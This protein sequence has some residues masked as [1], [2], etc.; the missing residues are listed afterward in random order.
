MKEKKRLA[1]LLSSGLSAVVFIQA[2]PLLPFA[3]IRA[4]EIAAEEALRNDL[5][6]YADDFPEGAVEF[7]EEKGSITEG[8]GDR[9][10]TVVRLGDPKDAM[11]VDVKAYDVTAQY[12]EDYTMYTKVKLKKNY[13]DDSQVGTPSVQAAMESGDFQFDIEEG[14]GNAVEL[15]GEPVAPVGEGTPFEDD[16]PV[17]E[18]QAEEEAAAEETAENEDEYEVV[19]AQIAEPEEKEASSEETESSGLRAAYRE[20]TGQDTVNTNWRGEYEQ[21][22]AEEAAKEA[23]NEVVDSFN[24]AF[25][26]LNFEPGE[27][28]KTIYIHVNDDDKA[29]SPESTSLILGNA[30]SGLIGVNMQYTVNIEDNE[31]AQPITFAMKD[32][33]IVTDR[34]ATYAEVTVERTSGIDY[35]ANLTYRTASGTAE[36]Y[37][38][39]MPVDGKSVAFAPGQTEQKV[40]IDLTGN[41]TVGSWFT[42]LIDQEMNNADE[43]RAETRVYIGSKTADSEDILN[44]PPAEPK[45]APQ[46]ISL[47]S[48]N[49]VKGTETMDGIKYETVALSGYDFGTW[50]SMHS[51]QINSLRDAAFVKLSYELLNGGTYGF[52]YGGDSLIGYIADIYSGSRYQIFNT[53][54]FNK[55]V[56]SLNMLQ[57]YYKMSVT[58]ITLYYP[59]YSVISANENQK[60]K[61]TNYVCTDKTLQANKT[62]DSPA[63]PGWQ[64]SWAG[65]T[66]LLSQNSPTG[67]FQNFSSRRDQGLTVDKWDVYAGSAGEREFISDVKVVGCDKDG[68]ALNIINQLKSEGW[69]YI[70]HDLNKNAGGMFI[71]LAYKTTPNYSEAIKDFFVWYG[72]SGKDKDSL[73]HDGYTY[74]HASYKGDSEFEKYKGDLNEN[75][76]GRDVYLFYSKQ[77]RGDGKGV[78]S[79]SFNSDSSS[80]IQCDEGGAADLNKGAGG[81]Y[82]YMHIGKDYTN[83]VGTL[84]GNDTGLFTYS[85]INNI[86]NSTPKRTA[87]QNA[88]NK[89]YVS[90]TYSP[91]KATVEFKAEEASAVAFNGNKGETAGFKVGQKLECTQID[92][93][94]MTICDV[95]EGQEINPSN[96]HR[97]AYNNEWV[98]SNVVLRGRIFKSM[99]LADIEKVNKKILDK[100]NTTKSSI[101]ITSDVD[102]DKE[103]FTACYNRPTLKYEYTPSENSVTNEA[104]KWGGIYVTP[105]DDPEDILG[106]SDYKTPLTITSPDLEVLQTIYVANV[107]LDANREI[108]ETIDKQT[109]ETLKN[110]TY[111]IWTYRDKESGMNKSAMGNSFAHRP[112]YNNETVNYHFKYSK[113]DEVMQGLSGKVYTLEVPLFNGSN[114]KKVKTPAV[115]VQLLVGG[116]NGRSGSDGSYTID[117]HFDINDN[118]SVF[119]KYDSLTTL[120]NVAIS[121]NTKY[122]IDIDVN[123]NDALKVVSSLME[124]D[125]LINT[126]KAP[127]GLADI[128]RTYN[129]QTADG[130]TLED[131]KYYLTVNAKGSAG[132]VPK[133]AEFRVYNKKGEYKSDLTKRVAFEQDGINGSLTYEVNPMS[134]TGGKLEVGD[135]FTV[136]LYDTK[137][138]KYFEHHTG[139]VVAEPLTKMFLFN[140]DSWSSDSDN[141]FIKA[142]GN[143]SYVYDF[144]LDVLTQP[145]TDYRDSDNKRH[146]F[147]YIGFGNTTNDP[148][149]LFEHE[150]KTKKM[151]EEM[152]NGTYVP[153]NYKE[154]SFQG[155]SSLGTDDD[156]KPT[157]NSSWNLKINIAMILDCIVDEEEGD[158]KGQLY[159]NDFL[160]IAG[161]TAKYDRT[162]TVPVKAVNVNIALHFAVNPLPDGYGSGV[163]WHFYTDPENTTKK[164]MTD[165]TDESKASDNKQGNSTINLLSWKGVKSRGDIGFNAEIG[166]DVNVSFKDILTVGG[167][168]N[169]QVENDVIY[170]TDK[171]FDD[172]GAVFLTPSVYIKLTFL[173]IPLWSTTFD[174]YWGNNHI[175]KKAPRKLTP[176]TEEEMQT[177]ILFNKTSEREI[178]DYNELY[179]DRQWGGSAFRQF[180]PG[181]PTS[182]EAI[183]EAVLQTGFYNDTDIRIQDLGNGKYI[184]LFI[185]LVLGRAT[186][187]AFGAYYSIY[188]GKSWSVPQ[189]LEDDGT[190]DDVP[191]I[192]NAGSKGWLIAWSDASRKID[193]NEN[194]GSMLN[195]Y[196]LTGRFFN[197]ET[198]EL[199]DVMEITKT[200]GSDTVCDSSPEISYYEENGKE[201][202]KIY[203]T[204]SEYSVS[205]TEDGEVIGDILNPYELKAVRNYDFENDKWADT[206]F[207]NVK[208]YLIN[209]RGEEGYKTY[210]D[211]WYGQEFLT[212]APTLEVNETLDDLGYWKEGTTATVAETDLSQ[213]MAQDSAVITYNNLSLQAYTLDK[214]GMAQEDHDENLY[215]QIYNYHDDEYHHPILISGN[216][217]EISD[218]K[219]VRMPVKADD[220]TAEATYLYWLED[221]NI[222]RINITNL[223]KN[224]LVEG[225]TANGQEYYYINKA[226]DSAFEPEQVLAEPTIS[227]NSDGEKSVDSAITSFKVRQNG[228]YNYLMWT[229]SIQKF[230]EN[231]EQRFEQQLFAIRENS[232]TGEITYPVQMTDKTDQYINKF[233]Y[234]VTDNGELDVLT[235]R[236]TLGED[237]HPDMNTSE[238]VAFHIKPSDKL[239]ISD[240]SDAS[241]AMNDDGS[242]AAQVDLTLENKNFNTQKNIVVEVQDNDGNVVYTTDSPI[243]SYEV[244]ET[245][246]DDGSVVFEE[247]TKTDNTNKL[248]MIGGQK[249]PVSVNIPMN[250]DGNYSGKI[251]LKVDGNTVETR[252]LSGQLK[253]EL[254]A[255]DFISAVTDRNEIRLDA[256]VKNDNYLPSGEETVK[257]GYVDADGKQIE[258]GTVN[259]EPLDANEETP[260]NLT[261][262][263]SF[264]KFISQLEEDGSLTDSLQLYMACDDFDTV[265]STVCLTASSEEYKLM[266]GLKNFDAK[267]SQYNY[268]GGLDKLESFNVGEKAFM[269]LWLE[270]DFAQNQKQYTNRTKLVWEEKSDSVASITKDGVITAKGDGTTTLNGYIVPIDTES[271]LYETGTSNPVDNY[272]YKPSA[273]VIPISANV[274]VGDGSTEK[275]GNIATDIEILSMAAK[276]Y[277]S[278]NDKVVSTKSLKVNDDGKYEISLFDVNNELADKYVIDP[279]TGIGVNSANEAVNLPQTGM[280][281]IVEMLIIITSVLMVGIGLIVVMYSRKKREEEIGSKE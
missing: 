94:T 170:S 102:Y 150:T 265:Y 103:I 160:I 267:P 35:Y 68:D 43:E 12:G 17:E 278:K 217:S 231:D 47:D 202:M 11:S 235:D 238:L 199:S 113:P 30:T 69:Q 174:W 176:P 225:K 141:F 55:D 237:G 98:L 222:K 61:G 80:A 40:R 132:F 206:Y 251:V 149:Q 73:S 270:G 158:R 46:I 49:V 51:Y 7:Y 130:M 136:T 142:L 29:E 192:C 75:A 207:G 9:E 60:L 243:A 209:K 58:G 215:L 56:I 228:D 166:A 114:T 86:I 144:A 247:L 67:Y 156:F 52:I 125:Q 127:F 145:G 92:K 26:T 85:D 116:F 138:N 5:L 36:S 122:D 59:T 13:A 181:N 257:Y 112:W 262:S 24:G 37:A 159:F 151:L 213:A 180:A 198:N 233:D 263:I 140:Y 253:P 93:V 229:E 66:V 32:T 189:L 196:D 6:A 50:S 123:D 261:A 219:F 147:S 187:D 88:Q 20:Q 201:F 234:V 131:T 245:V 70:H 177:D 179:A 161:C 214:G 248:D 109:G 134:M 23:D 255:N 121:T 10:I 101:Q 244:K 216:D 203:Y 259:L 76:G 91:K 95:T 79:I 74:Y 246:L 164:Y 57:P 72:S 16:A 190:S 44:L 133:E 146:M 195:T 232:V 21:E 212:L 249:L 71:Y 236:L 128:D 155:G 277:M 15:E 53:S 110:R 78:T 48:Y 115:G 82:I 126:S 107:V 185:D 135:T 143:I 162:W 167:T 239:V 182:A 275:T 191:T 18:T 220:G 272:V 281:S 171:E 87:V 163:R 276:D 197:A 211:T 124:K 208:E 63:I 4:E 280:N 175:T 200:G 33:E 100:D 108:F 173:K 38:A 266:T 42:V 148:K 19:E 271:I 224:S 221:F 2:L 117:P 129:R 227:I 62:F 264:D 89:L 165:E 184:A 188:D 183:T 273:V 31:E 41:G 205:S 269:N 27:Y 168:L 279:K 240:V 169:V 157:G 178:V 241:I 210:V 139:I 54:T 81:D 274:T 120:N 242:L 154:L 77:D 119:A 34:S 96:I 172:S 25:L 45:Q 84:S 137:G 254:S 218:L 268:D 230:D 204:K 258:L 3:Q 194:V 186:A 97:A 260:V 65:E 99:K 1:R 118:V 226:A 83:Y 193:E 105:Y 223:V 14:E 106:S 22:L 8:D 39:Y 111:T 153:E 250:R 90:P 152:A 64:S 252:E 28:K 104:R 256:T